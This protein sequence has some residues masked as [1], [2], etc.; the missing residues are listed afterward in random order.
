MTASPAL[1]TQIGRYRVL[2]RLGAGAMGEL[3]C[4]LD[5]GL[6]RKV[7][8]KILAEEHR[9]AADLRQRFVREAKAIAALSHPNVVLIYFI[10]EHE[11]RPYFVMEYLAGIDLG[12][13]VRHRG[14]ISPGDAAAVCAQTAAGLRE[15][16]AQGIV[17]RDVKPS[18]LLV[19][20]RGLVKVTDFGLAKQEVIGP[21]LTQAGMVVG[22]PDYIAPEQARG[23]PIDW[24]VDVYALGCTLHH[25]ILG[26]PPFR[27]PGDSRQHYMTVVER[28]LAEPAPHLAQSVPGIDPD[29]ASL[30]ARMM[31]KRPA[32]RPGYDEIITRLADVATRL[33]GRVPAVTALPATQSM[34]RVARG[35]RGAA[36]RSSAGPGPRPLIPGWL[37]ALTAVAL[38]VFLAGVGLRLL[39]WPQ[40]PAAPA[41]AARPD[42]G[43]GAAAASAPA[44]VDPPTGMVHV[45]AD[46][47]HGAFF[48][49]RAP[50]TNRRVADWDHAHAA[51]FKA[52][53]LDAAA[54]MVSFTQARAFAG[55]TGMRLLRDS[56]FHAL[57]DLGVAPDAALWEWVE[58]PDPG[59]PKQ[60]AR[61][62][63]RR[64]TKAADKGY[65][66]VT[67]RLA[68]DAR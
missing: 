35:A 25:L 32:E 64:T 61:R 56:E 68:Q 10:D 23:E 17:H 67:F 50:I 19:T 52:D 11:G 20:E 48:V 2:E 30:C 26:Q 9:E 40:P 31:S 42:G 12:R 15:A 65:A 5:E 6:G 24:R 47:A 1:P 58:G 55:S 4:A 22:T 13:L 14:P 43:G 46:A 7:A 59:A 18:N 54:T 27:R 62:A 37:Y 16:A 63:D 28:H 53:R 57:K 41:P 36:Q 66:D 3:Y 29:L 8:I 34:P 49:A 60:P 45:P 44:P 51:R 38:A 33:G 39:A 21:A